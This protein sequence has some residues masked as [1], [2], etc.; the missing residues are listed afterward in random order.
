VVH[1][2]FVDDERGV[3]SDQLVAIVAGE[4]HVRVVDH[5][6]SAVPVKDV[7]PVL[8]GFDDPFVLLELALATFPIGNVSEVYR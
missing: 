7:D 5:G 2:L 3:A 1:H 8:D 4:R 6:E